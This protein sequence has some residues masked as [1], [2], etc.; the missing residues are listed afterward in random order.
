MA[1]EP[2]WLG[3]PP[4]PFAPTGIGIGLGVF[5]PSLETNRASTNRPRLPRPWALLQGLTAAV[6]LDFPA[7]RPRQMTLFREV[8]PTRRE[9]AVRTNRGDRQ[10]GPREYALQERHSASCAS[11][12]LRPSS[13]SRNSPTTGTYAGRTSRQ[14]GPKPSPTTPRSEPRSAETSRDANPGHLRDAFGEPSESKEMTSGA[15]LVACHLLAGERFA[16]VAEATHTPLRGEKCEGL[17][18]SPSKPDE[19]QDVATASSRCRTADRK[20]SAGSHDLRRVR[21]H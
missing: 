18:T 7:P 17:T 8:E 10:A 5:R 14:L 2:Y 6:S 13:A 3:S 19:R 15:A 11:A 21:Q 16:E 20:R 12:R 1:V 9:A 4:P